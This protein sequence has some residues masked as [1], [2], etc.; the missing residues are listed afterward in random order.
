M[1]GRN[2]NVTVFINDDFYDAAKT[3]S[4][5][6]DNNDTMFKKTDINT[7]K[8]K[9]WAI[10]NGKI[11]S[12]DGKYTNPKQDLFKTLTAAHSGRDKT[13]QYIHKSFSEIS[14]DVVQL[15]VSLRKPHLQQKSVKDRVKKPVLKPLPLI[16]SFAKIAG[17]VSLV[18][19]FLLF[20]LQE[21]SVKV[22]SP[23]SLQMHLQSLL[24]L[25]LTYSLS[26]QPLVFSLRVI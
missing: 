12:K 25:S 18:V 1:K 5:N 7:I 2:S 22:H 11:I 24:N 20:F 17:P 21:R 8:C 19:V 10:E 9:K 13:E 23:C 4:T 14:Q 16:Q 6:G 15:F 3:W 26:S